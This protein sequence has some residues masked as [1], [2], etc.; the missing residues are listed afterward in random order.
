MVLLREIGGSPDSD[1]D[2]VCHAVGD[3]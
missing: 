3:A 1:G 2:G